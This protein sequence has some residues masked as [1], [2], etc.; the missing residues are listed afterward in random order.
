MRK[1][2]V[3]AVTVACLLVGAPPAAAEPAV[4]CAGTPSTDITLTADMWCNRTWFPAI[5]LV[6]G[7]DPDLGATC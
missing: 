3:L 5:T 7:A 4:R 1:E 2:L 6:D